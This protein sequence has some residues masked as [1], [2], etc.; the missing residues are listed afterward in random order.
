MRKN[1]GLKLFSLVLALIVW[2]QIA[3]SSE[4]RTTVRLP[5]VLDNLPPEIT[6][7]DLPKDVPFS[8][9]G[10]GIDLLR[11]RFSATKVALDAANL[12]PGIDKL[13]LDDYSL[14]DLPQNSGVE[15]IGPAVESDLSFSADVLHH[16][17]VKVVPAF[18]NEA[19]RARYAE[20]DFLLSPDQIR[21]N[22]PRREIRDLKTVST[23]P[24]SI[25]MLSQDRFDIPISFNSSQISST[26]AKV[27]VSR[28]PLRIETRVFEALRVDSGTRNVFPQTVTLKVEGSPEQLRALKPG[29]FAVKTL[30]EPDAAGWIDL[31]VVLPEG[32][33]KY[34]L[35]PERVRAR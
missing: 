30:G 6:L 12:R 15:V 31:E 32:L 22:G 33:D 16:R 27:S 4:H 2:L 9:R 8:V 29:S 13:P 1:L 28:V 7:S 17:S 21:I 18:E 3:L 5:V 24:I 25:Q 14:R 26:V 10:T 20:L 34:A 23:A 11:L 19:T 35:T